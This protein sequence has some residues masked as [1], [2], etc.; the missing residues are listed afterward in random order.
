MTVPAPAPV[1]S[2]RLLAKLACPRCYQRLERIASSDGC[3]GIGHMT[4]GEASP[5]GASRVAPNELP[6]S[7]QDAA[8]PA[9]RCTGCRRTYPVEHGVPLLFPEE[10]PADWTVSQKALYDGIAPHYDESIPRHVAMHYLRK[11]IK[12]V[13]Q[14]AGSGE[15]V[16]DVGC[17]TGT[18]SA[19]I[20]ASGYDVYGVDASTGMLAQ[21]G[22][23][24]RGTPVAG[25][26]ERLPFA[27]GAFDLALT[28]ATLH[29]ISN[30]ERI[31]QTLREMC[32]VTRPGGHVAVWDHNPHNPYWPL[33][34]QR[35]P[36]DTGQE[37]LVPQEEILAGLRAAGITDLSAHRSGFVPD[38]TPPA[39]LALAALAENIVER[40]PGVN[41]FCAHNVVVARKN[42]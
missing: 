31:A 21:L 18:L 24:G 42:G 33:L 7:E 40:T 3:A 29:H 2:E 14:L 17:G 28:V 38:F 1:I 5:D 34:M 11:R 36:Q 10:R 25:F 19:A 6:G 4:R 20:R 32:R 35:V 15:A 41:R 30:P 39:L 16:L 26:G 8:A 22:A 23:A 9:L 12:L 13:R 27:T 37:R